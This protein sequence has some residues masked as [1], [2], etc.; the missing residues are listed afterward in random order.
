MISKEIVYITLLSLFCLSTVIYTSTTANTLITQ[1]D[2]IRNHGDV[3]NAMCFIDEQEGCSVKRDLGDPCLSF[4][5]CNITVTGE[6]RNATGVIRSDPRDDAH[7]VDHVY[8]AYAEYNAK[9]EEV[10]RLAWTKKDLVVDG[11]YMANTFFPI[12]LAASSALIF[13][14]C[15]VEAIILFRGR[16][17]DYEKVV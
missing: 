17:K 6:L 9:T 13:I 4:V 3:L 8:A 16:K 10:A 11:R 12:V 2:K 7:L 15:T 1:V 5:N 14:V